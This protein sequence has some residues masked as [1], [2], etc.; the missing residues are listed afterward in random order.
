[1]PNIVFYK[2]SMTIVGMPMAVC[3]SLNVTVMVL[4]FFLA[5]MKKWLANE[6][7]FLW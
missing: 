5:T 4:Y 6:S 7:G 1:M 2:W 3:N